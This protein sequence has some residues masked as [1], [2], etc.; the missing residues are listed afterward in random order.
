MRKLASGL[1][2]PNPISTVLLLLKFDR[3]YTAAYAK[4]AF[5]ALSRA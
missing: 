5:H 2:R 1:H 3:A 4:F